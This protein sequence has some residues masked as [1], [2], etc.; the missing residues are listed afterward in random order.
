MKKTFEEKL[1]GLTIPFRERY[2]K[3]QSEE[4]DKH[5]VNV[6]IPAAYR[7]FAFG[8]TT[9]ITLAIRLDYFLSLQ[10][11]VMPEFRLGDAVMFCNACYRPL[12]D[13]LLWFGRGEN[14]AQEYAK[15]LA[16][17]DALTEVVNNACEPISD[18]LLRKMHSLQGLQV[19]N[20][21]TIPM[22]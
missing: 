21:R 3:E 1:K 11:S 12:S 6:D 5:I 4:W 17:C 9:H 2:M 22:A 19:K 18:T 8:F 13:W 10:A 15:Y 16:F 20:N 7:S 14:T